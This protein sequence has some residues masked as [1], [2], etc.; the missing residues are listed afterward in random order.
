MFTRLL[1]GSLKSKASLL[2]GAAVCVCLV[3]QG[4]IIAG[5]S[6]QHIE[7]ESLKSTI[8]PIREASTLLSRHF[9]EAEHNVRILAELSSVRRA[10]TEGSAEANKDVAEVFQLI[11]KNNP[12]YAQ[13]RLIGV[14][15]AGREVVRVDRRGNTV[16][17]V[18]EYDLQEKGHREYFRNTMKIKQGEVYFSPF[19][20]N[21]ENRKI[22]EPYEPVVR[23]SAPVF[24][25]EAALSKLGIIIINIHSELLFSDVKNIFPDESELF[26]ANELGQYLY[27][28]NASLRYAFEFGR[29][30]LIHEQFKKVNPL[31]WGVETHTEFLAESAMGDEEFA[32][33]FM[34][35]QLGSGIYKRDLVV[36]VSQPVKEIFVG[37]GG[38]WVTVGII[39]FVLSI[40]AV[41]SIRAVLQKLFRPLFNMI[42]EIGAHSDIEEPLKLP[43]ER[44]DETGILASTINRM[45]GRIKEQFYQ[46]NQQKEILNNV[47]QSAV[48]A[49]VQIDEKGVIESWNFA[50]E[51]MFGYGYDEIIGKNIRMLM[52]DDQAEQHDGFL[53]NYQR[54]GEST[55]I[56]VGR[57]AVARKKN[58]VL[59]P[60]HLSV[61]EFEVDG[62]RKFTGV[63][64]DASKQRAFEDSLRKL[65]C[66]DGLT[67]AL[68]QRAFTERSII[69]A[70]RAHRQQQAMCLML[71]DIDFFKDL[72]DTFG[73]KAGDIA[74]KFFVKEARNKL[75]SHDI[76]GRLGGDEFAIL[77]PATSL[78]EA[79]LVAKRV[80]QS[81]ILKPVSSKYERMRITMSM[82]VA[83]INL[84]QGEGYDA[85]FTRAD[86]MLYAA[87]ENGRNCIVEQKPFVVD[88]AA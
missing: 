53:E 42:V 68:N 13:V 83:Q 47:I 3:V 63:I 1:S 18:N 43:V 14:R 87:K 31:V 10:L 58:G 20:L 75:R 60:V 9:D 28:P 76:I 11:A 29:E 23:I 56:G 15:H 2:T 24:E 65:A 30:A 12:A 4:G 69:E 79:V 54:T 49:I 73:H 82:G 51:K 6:H 36:G 55:T 52:A 22:V 8:A 67:G 40:I 39:V 5:L 32:A 25:G 19:E 46:I 85:L 81:V 26:I 17:L 70:G 62:R 66:T 35:I 84:Q 64:Y 33:S 77:C 44:E 37:S 80:R 21:R 16:T 50:A 59:F 86:Q 88:G 38:F 27:H 48:D 45:Q 34:R 74:L 57:E 7:Q 71:V 41:F 72:N 61:G 78:E